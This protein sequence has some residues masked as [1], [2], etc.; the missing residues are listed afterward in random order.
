MVGI[1]K[2]F[3]VLSVIVGAIL[4]IISVSV[5]VIFLSIL[6][7]AG[8]SALLGGALLVVFA[9]IAEILAEMNDKLTPIHKLA[10]VL[11]QKY[12]VD[13]SHVTAES[14]GVTFDP[15]NPIVDP[16]SNLPAGSK[17]ERHFKRRVALL[18]D[19]TVLG[20]TDGG[21]RRFE[22]FEEWQRFIGK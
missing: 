22:T 14:G 11:E 7:P 12:H 20:E 16:L 6:L 21:L 15:N 4:L 10:L 8:A 5:G 9:R 18:P 19:G 1:I 2:V 3:G 17:I 13:Q